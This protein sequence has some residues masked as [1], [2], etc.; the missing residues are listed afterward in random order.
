MLDMAMSVVMFLFTVFLIIEVFVCP[1]RRPQFSWRCPLLCDANSTRLASECDFF[2]PDPLNGYD[3]ARVAL[4]PR[5]RNPLSRTVSPENS[6][7][8]CDAALII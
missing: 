7:I 5:A 1:D 3:A 2:M 6:A 8:V 4:F